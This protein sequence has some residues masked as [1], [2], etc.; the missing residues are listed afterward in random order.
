MSLLQFKRDVTQK[1][2]FLSYYPHKIPL[3]FLHKCF[4]FSIT[5]LSKIATRDVQLR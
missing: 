1:M 4:F 2:A 3:F 5:M